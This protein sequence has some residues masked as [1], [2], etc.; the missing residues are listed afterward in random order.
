[1]KFNWG[2]GIAMLYTG[3]VIGILTLVVMSSRQKVDLVAENYYEEELIF[4]R[5]I[6]KIERTKALTEPLLWGVNQE[7]VQLQFPENMNGRK[8]TGKVKFYCPSDN[9]KD[10]EFAINPAA[11]LSQLIPATQLASGRYKLQVEWQAD[12]TTYWNEGAIVINP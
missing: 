11:D 2:I 3:F 9:R 10:K 12:S 5:K 6:D 8:I 7:G 1:M 4:Q